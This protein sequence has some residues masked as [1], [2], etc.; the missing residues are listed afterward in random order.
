MGTFCENDP[1]PLAPTAHELFARLK[2]R[3]RENP[4]RLVFPEGGDPR[5][6]TAAARLAEERLADP[7]L[8]TEPVLDEY[9]AQLYFE[10]RRPKGITED[11]ARRA[12]AVPLYRAALMVAAGLADGCVGG[13]VNTTGDTVRAALHCIG[14]A[15]GASLLS[16][17][18]LIALPE[19]LYGSGG[20]LCF[21]DC[22]V[23]VA[24]DA[25]QLAGIAIAASHTT[26]AI[27]GVE[28]AV[29][30]LSFST[31]GSAAHEKAALVRRAL[32]IVRERAP[33]LRVDGELQADAALVEHIGR[34]KAPT[35]RV[36]GLT[37]TLVFPDLNSGN[38]AY[39]LVERLAGATA[40]GPILQGLAR[41]M[42]DLSRG[43]SWQDIYHMAILT[44][45]Q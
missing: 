35:S 3:A 9:L 2:R 7:I 16:S 28:P 44:A 15:P 26:R 21:A 30:L 37:N 12:A 34:S 27:L 32:E 25:G 8:L 24:P 1:L 29:A 43:C 18:M 5:V 41:P 14:L 39:K 10:R 6:V 13:A 11:D 23:V 40:I 20:L 42:N 38:I 33:E 17:A 22:A 19:P 4:K 45:C 36:T 31:H